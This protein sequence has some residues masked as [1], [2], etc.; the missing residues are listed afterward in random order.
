MN[1]WNL[2]TEL[3][4]DGLLFR[5]LGFILHTGRP[6]TRNRILGTTVKSEND[7]QFDFPVDRTLKEWYSFTKAGKHS[8]GTLN[9]IQQFTF[10]LAIIASRPPNELPR[11]IALLVGILS[12]KKSPEQDGAPDAI[13]YFVKVIRQLYIWRRT[14]ESLRVEENS[15]KMNNFRSP[16]TREF[17]V[18]EKL[19]PRQ[20]WWVD[21][22]V[23]KNADPDTLKEPGPQNPTRLDAA[24]FTNIIGA[25]FGK[26]KAARPALP[27]TEKRRD[28]PAQPPRVTSSTWRNLFAR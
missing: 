3:E 11:E 23:R 13:D 14:P 19:G 1:F 26:P 20:R 10:I 28:T 22:Y 17:V 5:Y 2:P 15:L 9:Q 7:G 6:E 21:G 4:T 27:G 12:E 16:E 25:Y 24:K 8:Y 18:A